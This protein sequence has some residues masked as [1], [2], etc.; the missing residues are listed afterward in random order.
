MCMTR[1]ITNT[2]RVVVSL[3][4]RDVRNLFRGSGRIVDDEFLDE[5]RN[6]LPKVGVDQSAS[7][8]VVE[9]VRSTWRGRTVQMDQV[10]QTI[11]MR[12]RVA[13]D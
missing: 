7:E 13:S 2:I 12:V 6:S 9:Q 8:W 1:G 4:S 10:L 5:L 11:R 3:L